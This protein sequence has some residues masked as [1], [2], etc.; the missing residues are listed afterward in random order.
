MSPA[1][2]WRIAMSRTFAIGALAS[3]ARVRSARLPHEELPQVVKHLKGA[4][5]LKDEP[6]GSTLYAAIY[7]GDLDA[8]GARQLVDPAYRSVAQGGSVKV[9][10]LLDGAVD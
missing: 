8:E 1:S 9:W 4:K 3:V 2:P 7:G 6:Q 10:V 5:E